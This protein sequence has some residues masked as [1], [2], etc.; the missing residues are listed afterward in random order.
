MIWQGIKNISSIHFR[1]NMMILHHIKLRPVAVDSLS[2]IFL[3]CKFLLRV[4]LKIIVFGIEP[5]MS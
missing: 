5:N 1:Y 2:D 3:Y 4:L